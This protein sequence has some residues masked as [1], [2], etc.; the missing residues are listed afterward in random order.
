MWLL[1][2]LHSGSCVDPEL[3]LRL[4]LGFFCSPYISK[5]SPRFLVLSHSLKNPYVWILVVPGALQSTGIPFRAYFPTWEPPGSW[6]EWRIYGTWK[7]SWI[8][9]CIA[10][11]KKKGWSWYDIFCWTKHNTKANTLLDSQ[12]LASERTAQGLVKQFVFASCTVCF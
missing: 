1:L 6:L 9:R 3:G 7:N 8:C 4:G 10:V 5:H 2:L 11:K 12:M